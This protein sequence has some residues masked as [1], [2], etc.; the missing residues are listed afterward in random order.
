MYF[1]VYT[2]NTGAHERVKECL[3][4]HTL[5][6]HHFSQVQTQTKALLAVHFYGMGNLL[7][8]RKV[9]RTLRVYNRPPYRTSAFQIWT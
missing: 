6:E 9:G 1:K 8:T 2:Y 7:Y 4:L 3:T 5:M